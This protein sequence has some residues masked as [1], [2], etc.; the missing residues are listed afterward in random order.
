[1]AHITFEN[2]TIQYPIY[3]GRSQSL[4]N[5]LVRIGTGGKL[6]SEAGEVVTVTALSN[7]SFSLQ[8]GD[9]V[10][11]VGHNGA[12]K[13]TLL[14]TMAGIYSPASG[15]IQNFPATKTSFAWGYCLVAR[16][17]KLKV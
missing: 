2:V 13:T 9:S 11:L 14:R 10:G 1:M 7:A 6:S 17:K 15:G 5:Q 16:T 3:N 4:R 8:D 12:G